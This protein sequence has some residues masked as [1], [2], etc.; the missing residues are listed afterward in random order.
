MVGKPQH[1]TLLRNSYAFCTESCHSLAAI[2]TMYHLKAD[3]RHGGIT[4][5][6]GGGGYPIARAPLP[7]KLAMYVPRLALQHL[8]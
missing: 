3:G 7:L 6:V 4:R 5:V 1:V 2:S 8:T